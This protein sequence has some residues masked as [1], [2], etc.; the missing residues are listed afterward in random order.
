MDIS[1][2]VLSGMSAPKVKRGTSPVQEQWE[3]LVPVTRSRV[4]GHSSLLAAPADGFA[5]GESWPTKQ[6]APK[7]KSLGCSSLHGQ[8]RRHGAAG[9]A[10]VSIF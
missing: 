8:G 2:H 7:G 3:M 10:D 1:F 4:E 5:V 6:K 9:K